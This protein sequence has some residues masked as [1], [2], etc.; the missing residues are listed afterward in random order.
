[1]VALCHIAEQ[2][3]TESLMEGVDPQQPLGFSVKVV[4]D[5]LILTWQFG[6]HTQFA[7]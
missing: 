1:M 3:P 5:P 4:K 2:G 7:C 6:L